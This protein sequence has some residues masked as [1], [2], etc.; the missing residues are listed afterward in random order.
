MLRLQNKSTGSVILNE[1]KNL[2]LDVPIISC[3]EYSIGVKD[4][5]PVPLVPQND[6]AWAFDLQTER[7]RK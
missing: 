5:S 6:T 2:V 7:S 4:N 3:L 1:V